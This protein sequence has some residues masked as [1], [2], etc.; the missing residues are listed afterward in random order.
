[1]KASWHKHRLD[2]RF[3]AITSRD[4]LTFKDTYYIKVWDEQSPEVTGIEIGRAH[5]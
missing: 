3:T 2:F 4:S 5:V 1:M